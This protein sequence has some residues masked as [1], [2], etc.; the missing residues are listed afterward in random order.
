MPILPTLISSPS[1]AYIRSQLDTGDSAKTKR[2]LQYICRMYRT[3]HRVHVQELVGLQQ[4]IIGILYTR[5]SDEKLR[6]WALNALAQCGNAAISLECVSD[7]LKEFSGDAQTTA[8]AV[9]AI[10]K[11]HS[12]PAK[13]FRDMDALDPQVQILAALQHVGVSEL[14]V[15]CLPI[16]IEKSSSDILK[17]GIIVV[18]LNKAPANLFHPRHSNATI[19]GVLGAHHDPIVAQYTV[20]AVAENENISFSDL[21]IPLS[22]VDGLPTNVRAWMYRALAM[23]QVSAQQN[24]ERIVCGASDIEA[25]VR[26]GLAIGLRDTYYDGL[27]AVVLDWFFSEA[28]MEVSHSLLDHIVKFWARCPA[29]E[30]VALEFYE[31]E[32]RNS[33]LR[34]RMDAHAA[35]TRLYGHFQ[36]ISY[37]GANDLFRRNVVVNNNIYGNVN[38]AAVALGGDA[39]NVGTANIHYKLQDIEIMQAE[40]A[41]AIR[42]IHESDATPELKEEALGDVK[43]AQQDPSPDKLFKA[44]EVLNKIKDVAGAGSAITSSLGDIISKISSYLSN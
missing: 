17:L 34:Q 9:A 40:L 8:A 35:G 29:Y 42:K 20:W 41:K 23:S 1:V 4:S 31:K 39:S 3:G 15:N 38:A 24:H 26:L 25:E 16:N 14:D 10:Y 30:Q 21:R 27:D 5:K 36:R 13:F 22:S 11:M 2:A 43:L 44:V 6:R 19:V 33:L 12:D 7:I 37:D 18:G 28:D 32:G